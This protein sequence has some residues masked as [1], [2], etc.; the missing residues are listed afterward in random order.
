LTM[1]VLKAMGPERYY[2][3]KSTLESK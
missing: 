1:A 3:M 2:Q